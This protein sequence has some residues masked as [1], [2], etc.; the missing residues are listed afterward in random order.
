MTTLHCS[1][2]LQ[3]LSHPFLPIRVF[4]SSH[5]I[6]IPNPILRTTLIQFRRPLPATCSV[7]DHGS[8][9]SGQFKTF[10]FP[11]HHHSFAFD[12]HELKHHVS[13]ISL[14]FLVFIQLG[15]V[16]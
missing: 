13:V 14:N 4:T 8:T 2:L 11:Y 1:N 10:L 15:R 7:A 6:T 12:F 3:I 16:N 9:T 5:S